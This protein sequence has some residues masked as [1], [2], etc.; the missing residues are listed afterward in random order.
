MPQI[1]IGDATAS[2]RVHIDDGG[3]LGIHSLTGLKTAAAGFIARFSNP[4]SDPEFHSATFAAAFNSPSIPAGSG[5]VGLQAGV[6]SAVTIY[7]G[8]DS[9][10]FGGDDYD[11]VPIGDPECWVSFELDTV[12][13]AGL[14][15]PLS[16]GFGVSFGVSATPGF[17]TYVR[18]DPQTS[19]KE[20]IAQAIGSFAIAGSADD[21]LTLPPN[22]IYTAGVSGSISVTGSWF[23]PLSVNQLSLAGADLPF[24]QNVAVIPSA[25][26]SLSGQI[27][28]TGAFTSRFHRTSPDRIR[29]GIYKSK[30]TDFSVSF[31]AST[32]ITAG[33]P[34]R[35]DWIAKFFAAVA[36]K[37][38]TSSLSPEE[39]GSIQQVLSDS[40]NRSLSISLNAACSAS[41][42]DE[43]AVLYEIDVSSPDAATK[44]ALGRALKGDWTPLAK[45]PNAHKLRDVITETVEKTA[46]LTVN[47]LGLY[48]YRSIED[49]AASMRVVKNYDD[50][51]VTI[52]DTATASRI[53]A[54]STPYAA[55]GDQLRAA[56]YESFVATA[57]YKALSAGI[58][59]DPKFDA[60]QSYLL[61]KESMSYRQALKELNAG[62]ALS[63]LPFSLKTSL[64]SPGDTVHHARF[65]AS[66]NYGNDDVLRFF[67]SDTA[68]LTPRKEEDL[69]KLGR[70]V[71]AS[72][73]DPQDRTDQQRIAVLQS[74]TAWAGQ[75]ANPARIPALHYSDWFDITF[76]A[77]AIARVGPLLADAIR[78]G[79][80][81][82]GDPT[83]N[84]VFMK[85][86]AD[87]A[88]AIAASTNKT[89]AAFERAFAIC[90]MATLAGPGVPRT[91][92]ASWN[93]HIIFSTA[94][95]GRP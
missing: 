31:A 18:V 10:L 85:K 8:E 83:G 89:H 60:S 91:Y 78:F 24:L 61:Y 27:S 74:D 69:K 64:T 21:I 33:H 77:E 6:N 7:R 56:L 54:A 72:L 86:R 80:T 39:A 20:A 57:A 29:V 22:R 51:S 40:I 79:K 19:L 94:Q 25:D 34:G 95:P 84:A 26:V 68:T 41:R 43:A 1:T 11:P 17:V 73:L 90:V 14:S 13:G 88:R 65:S 93:G 30:G 32:G 63:V 44:D 59:A 87:V 42:S 70:T 12:V 16:D 45:L 28:L 15:V 5:S 4:V 62:Y 58:G 76:W 36:P 46:S 35:A 53:A 81:V 92:E 49:F 47:L 55:D 50:G 82:P 9:P 23:L 52:T 48:N 2:A 66:C 67:F 75:S 38:D 37:I 3:L 71:L